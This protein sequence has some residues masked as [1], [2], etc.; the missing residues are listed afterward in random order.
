MNG[1]ELRSFSHFPILTYIVY[2]DLAEI[3]KID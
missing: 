2:K 3:L 1:T